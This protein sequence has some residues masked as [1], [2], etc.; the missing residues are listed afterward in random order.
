LKDA[1]ARSSAEVVAAKE[2][3]AA[4]FAAARRDLEAGISELA[5]EIASRVLQPP[6]SPSREVR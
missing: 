6:R 5:A 3:V 4:E 1:R 2:R